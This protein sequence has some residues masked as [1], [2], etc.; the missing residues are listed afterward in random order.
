MRYRISTGS[1]FNDPAGSVVPAIPAGRLIRKTVQIAFCMWLVATVAVAVDTTV[2]LDA[3]PGSAFVV[4]D[5]ESN[6]LATV[7]SDGR[8]IAGGGGYDTVT[9]N[10]VGNSVSGPFGTISGGIG[11]VAG[12]NA[13]YGTVGGGYYNGAYGVGAT[14]AGG[15]YNT[16]SGAYGFVP[17]GLDSHASGNY[18]FAAGRGAVAAHEGAFVWGDST[19]NY[20]TSEAANQFKVRA[21]GGTKIF[22]DANASVGV[23]LVAGG[24]SWSGASDRNLKENLQPVDARMLLDALDAVPITTWN[25]KAQDDGIRHIGPMAQDF[26]AAFGVGE[27]NTH[28]SYSD[29][30]GVSLAAIQGLYRLLREQDAANQELHRTVEALQRRLE[31]IETGRDRVPAGGIQ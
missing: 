24:N 12:S 30:D 6:V 8:T 9:S 2:T 3:A 14:V 21:A 18:S 26:H 13:W 19:A 17:G 5:A 22:S 11:N 10:I 28:I 7:W 31:M 27:T 1:R 29:A 16:A 4:R 20:V 15:V 25:M 23:Q